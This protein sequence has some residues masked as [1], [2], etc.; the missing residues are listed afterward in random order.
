MEYIPE[1]I[2]YRFGGFELLSVLDACIKNDIGHESDQKTHREIY[3]KLMAWSA[4]YEIM[5][6]LW[7]MT[8]EAFYRSDFW[9]RL[10]QN[11]YAQKHHQVSS[12]DDG[13]LGTSFISILTSQLPGAVLSK[14]SDEEE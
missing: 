6:D 8:N 5:N 1:P 11:T 9:V 12:S 13:I 14:L 3:D 10:T 4:L 7:R 2:E